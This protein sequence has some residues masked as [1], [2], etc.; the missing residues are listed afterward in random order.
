VGTFS[1]RL[2]ADRL[3]TNPAHREYTEKT[4]KIPAKTI[5]PKP[6]SFYAK[7]MRDIED[8]SV[9]WAWVQTNNPWQS[10]PNINHW[11][12]AAREMDCFIV[13]SDAYPSVLAKVADLVLPAAMHFEK[14]G[15]FGNAERRTQC[16]R[17]QVLPQGQA[18]ADIW[19]TMEFAKR[20]K[21][22]DF[23]GEQKV[24]GLKAEGFEDGKLPSVLDEAVK[25]GYSPEDSLYK[26][27]FATPENMKYKWPDPA[28]AKGRDNH[29]IK[30]LGDGWFPEKALFQEYVVFGRGQAKDLA[31]FDWYYRDDVRGGK[32]PMTKNDK[33]EWVEGSWRFN[34]KY[35]PYVKKGAGFE[36]YGKLFKAI[37]SGNLD[38]VTDPK[39]VSVAGKAKIF[40]R[41]YA[42]PVEQPDA[43]Y[44]LWQCTGRVLEHW[45]TGTMTRRVPELHRSFPAAVLWMHPK[46]AE[47]RKLKR[48]D[49]VWCE[50]RRGK[51]QLRVETGG[52]NR[53]PRGY[54][55]A[56]FFDEG[57]L[58][59]KLVNDA[60]CPISKESDYK[61]WA[62]KVY[63]A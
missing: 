18:R 17:Q 63:K 5:N 41:P 61:K 33:G 43:N 39:P 54:V 4:W 2:P 60:T 36:F 3:I 23:W 13:V 44:D 52:R 40:F 53:M 62:V 20:F 21:L 25:M 24:P 31:D 8:G 1:H 46:D 42:A 32:W 59:N 55:Y 34:E 19:Q 27:L 30:L 47:A 26:V 49:L 56:P 15:M 37:P 29:V 51:I 58:V 28:V 16:W 22:K 57:V 10:H 45:H 38:G 14:W 50:S 7:I 9:K 6:G 11:L 12:K 48:D 35:D